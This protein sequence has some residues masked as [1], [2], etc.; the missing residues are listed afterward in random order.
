[1][2]VYFCGSSGA[3]KTTCAAAVAS[4][5]GMKLLPSASRRALAESGF[6]TYALLLADEDGVRRF[7]EAVF[8]IQCE[9]EDDGDFVSDRCVDHFVYQMMYAGMDESVYQS[10]EG[11]RYVVELGFRAGSGSAVVFHVPPTRKVF[12]AALT[13]N[14]RSEFLEWDAVNR[15]DGAIRFILW[16]NDVLHT[17]ITTDDIDER[18]ELAYSV[19]D[20]AI[21]KGKKS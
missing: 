15:F 17:R 14:E 21:A 4:R 18:C 2:R 12:E 5:Y 19:I 9:M 20:A 16:S 13:Q 8:R 1:M 6:D 10:R 11:R 7:Q 3:G